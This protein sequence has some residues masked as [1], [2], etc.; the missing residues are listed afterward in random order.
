M[1]NDLTGGAGEAEV[2]I[3]MN[4]VDNA[5]GVIGGLAEGPIGA[6]TAAAGLAAAALTAVT[7]AIGVVTKA[8]IEWG[9]SL[10]ATMLK[11][12]DTSAQA[13]GLKLIADTAGV[14]MDGVTRSL[15][16]MGKNLETVNGKMGTA[17]KVL[18]DLGISFK[19]TDGTLRNTTDI[20]GDVATKLS[21]M[22][23]GIQKTTYMMQLF[24][25]SGADM[26]EI[27]KLAANGGMQ[28][29][30]DQAKKMG[31]ALSP[32]QVENINRLK[33][34]M[35]LL[36]DAF[37]GAEVVL[38]SAF[39]PLLQS[40]VTW[41]QN[42]TAALMPAISQF[43]TFLGQLTGATGIKLPSAGGGGGGAG[44]RPTSGYAA[45]TNYDFWASQYHPAGAVNPYATAGASFGGLPG[46]AAGMQGQQFQVPAGLKTFEDAI[47][48][49]ATVMKKI[50][51]GKVGDDLNKFGGFVN[52]V[53][54]DIAQASVILSGLVGQWGAAQ[55]AE[56]GMNPFQKIATNISLSMQTWGAIIGT[57]GEPIE[58]GLKTLGGKI[59]NAIDNFLSI[60]GAGGQTTAQ[61]ITGKAGGGPFSGWAR[62]GDAP[63]GGVTPYTEYVYAPHGA[64]VYNQAQMSGASA[65]PMAS[66]GVI[67]GG[68]FSDADKRWL[69]TAFRDAILRLK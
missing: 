56:A 30:I 6:L 48:N 58:S 32:E 38:G 65:P 42:M 50:D 29:F 43:G 34:S 45:Q 59:K 55:G 41:I 66:G 37:T 14:S 27:L 60:L 62:V 68:A 25:R 31:L 28:S 40:A 69:A 16:L 36:K 54:S 21:N 67:G 53:A 15:D 12:G 24:G 2:K 63:G 26:N 64:M 22:P 61:R 13:A 1:L 19:N 33:E 51:W 17:G 8:T 52:T 9:E 47:G 57:L 35:N 49:F 11:L 4:A 7:T 5:S 10:H 18:T 44:G 39:V 20:F 23:D 46:G 3:V